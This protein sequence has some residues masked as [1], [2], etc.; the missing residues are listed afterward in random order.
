MISVLN[1][2]YDLWLLPDDPQ[3][4][5]EQARAYA[6]AQEGPG[7]PEA[8]ALAH[9]IQQAN[10]DSAGPGFL[11]IEPLT[12]IGDGVIVPSPYPQISRARAEVFPL[13]FAAGYAVYDPQH[14]LLVSPHDAAWG[15]LITRRNGTFPALTPSLIGHF[16]SDMQ[17]EDFVIVE[18]EDHLYMQSRRESATEYTL[19][20]RMGSPDEHY[21]TT[22]ESAE[23]IRSAFLAWLSGDADAYVN[24]GWRRIKV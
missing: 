15:T 16:V 8:D 10:D 7:T 3:A 12:G 2:S 5:A 6:L 22:L 18:V 9:A 14:G 17:V 11:S 19:E 13:A 20:M 21:A 1:M 4:T 24:L 23:E